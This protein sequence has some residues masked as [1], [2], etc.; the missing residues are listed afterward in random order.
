[1]QHFGAKLPS[2]ELKPGP[3]A[4]PKPYAAHGEVFAASGRLAALKPKPD[5]GLRAILRKKFNPNSVL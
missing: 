2:G 4:R 5:R 3:A 1:V